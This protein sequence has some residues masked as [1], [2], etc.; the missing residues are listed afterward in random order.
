MQPNRTTAFVLLA[1]VTVLTAPA[2]AQDRSFGVTVGPM[3]QL[4]D[5]LV[6]CMSFGAWLGLGRFEIDYEAGL[7]VWDIRYA[8][9]LDQPEQIPLALAGWA[10]TG[11]WDVLTWRTPRTATRLR[12]GL[13]RRRNNNARVQLGWTINFGL[14]VD[15]PI[16]STRRPF[17]RTAVRGLF[18]EPQVGV[19][20]PF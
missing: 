7:N 2:A 18:P 5:E 16:S 15:F 3:L 14:V 4:H 13:G 17:V 8:A 1:A 6:C 9:R 11:Y 20:F 10:V 12:A 19:G